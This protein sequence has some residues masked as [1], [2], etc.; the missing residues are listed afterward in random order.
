MLAGHPKLRNDLR[1]PTMEEIDIA[2][3]ELETWLPEQDYEYAEWRFVRV[4]GRWQVDE[5]R[6]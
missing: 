5:I 3:Q 6:K 4:G 1:R 2:Q